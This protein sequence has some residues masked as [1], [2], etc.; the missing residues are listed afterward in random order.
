MLQKCSKLLENKEKKQASKKIIN[1][2]QVE[3]I[4]SKIQNF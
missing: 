2:V 3:L 4:N 1:H